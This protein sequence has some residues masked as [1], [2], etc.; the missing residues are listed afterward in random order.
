MLVGSPI[1]P[2]SALAGW[3]GGFVGELTRRHGQTPLLTELAAKVRGDR[4]AA[5]PE[6][7][8]QGPPGQHPHIV[9]V[10]SALSAD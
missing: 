1:V 10:K 8:A 3:M 5:G 4:P 6:G 7:D 9:I 2:G